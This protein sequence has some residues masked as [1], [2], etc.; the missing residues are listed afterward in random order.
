MTRR[1]SSSLKYML[2][3]TFFFE[4]AKEPLDQD[5]LFRRIGRDE[6]LPYLIVPP[7]LPKA[8][9]LKDQSI[10]AAEDRLAHRT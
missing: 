8:P 5:V 3:D 2:P 9:A 4:T 1:A 10:I 6:F 7:G